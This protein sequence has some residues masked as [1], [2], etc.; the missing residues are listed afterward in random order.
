MRCRCRYVRCGAEWS[1]TAVME[2]EAGREERVARNE[3]YSPELEGPD[4]AADAPPPLPCTGQSNPTKFG[5]CCDGGW[6]RLCS[7]ASRNAAKRSGL[8]PPPDPGP[9]ACELPGGWF[10]SILLLYI[11]GS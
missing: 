11:G 10:L 8:P 2:M 7:S 3:D 4:G 9:D 1:M 6:C 5:P